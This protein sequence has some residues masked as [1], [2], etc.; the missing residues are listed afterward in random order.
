M[1]VDVFVGG[2]VRGAVVMLDRLGDV[3]VRLVVVGDDAHLSPVNVVHVPH[4]RHCCVD[5]GANESGGVWKTEGGRGK[6][7]GVDSGGRESRV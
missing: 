2:S 1:V 6:A 5:E 3:V 7:G 4:H